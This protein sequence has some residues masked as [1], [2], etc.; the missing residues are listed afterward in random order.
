MMKKIITF[1]FFTLALLFGSQ[2]VSAQSVMEINNT[3]NV[4][5]NALKKSIKFNDKT[6]EDVYQA[7]KLYETKIASLNKN[8]VNDPQMLATE[9]QN[10]KDRLDAKLKEL[11]TEEQYDVYKSLNTN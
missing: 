5:A 9:K 11:F 2:N 8:I 1:C 6:L 10:T 7:Y 3:A 4:K